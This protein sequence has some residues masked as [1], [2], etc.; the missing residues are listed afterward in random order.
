MA[1]KKQKQ[2]KT[3][4]QKMKKHRMKKKQNMAVVVVVAVVIMLSGHPF[5]RGL[6]LCLIIALGP[7]RA[8]EMPLCL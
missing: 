3:E 6:A 2:K 5:L 4:T 1:I 8:R 7:P